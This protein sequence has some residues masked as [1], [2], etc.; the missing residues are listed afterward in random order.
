MS[1]NTL[2]A[3]YHSRSKSQAVQLIEKKSSVGQFF[4][5]VECGY[6][7]A[8]RRLTIEGGQHRPYTNDV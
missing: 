2:L 6:L 8:Q 4:K 3:V 7:V 1:N 5:N